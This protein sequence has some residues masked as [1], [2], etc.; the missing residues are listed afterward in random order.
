MKKEFKKLAKQ[1]ENEYWKNKQ[2]LIVETY[3]LMG[4]NECYLSIYLANT[5]I[6]LFDIQN[7]N[8]FNK[9]DYMRISFFS[10]K[11]IKYTTKWDSVLAACQ[12]LYFD[13]II[14]LKTFKPLSEKD[15]LNAT[16]YFI[17]EILDLWLIF[18]FEFKKQNG[19][20]QL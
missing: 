2:K 19:K 16:E 1:I 11:K 8:G 17:R 14:T 4:E 9:I 13:R 3:E 6:Y 20:I 5:N 12:P 7:Y 10:P 18:N 15:I